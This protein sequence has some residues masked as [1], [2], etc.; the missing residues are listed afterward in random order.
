MPSHLSADRLSA[1]PPGGGPA[2]AVP[3]RARR[4]KADVGADRRGTRYD[5]SGPWGRR[6]RALYYLALR[7][8]VDLVDLDGLDGF[9]GFDDLDEHPARLGDGPRTAPPPAP[10]GPP[11]VGAPPS[12][13]GSAEWNLLTD[14]VEWSGEFYDILGRAPSTP[15]LTLDELPSLVLDAD[16]A[17]LTA[18]ITGCLVDGRPI[19]GEFRVVRPDGAV[20]TVHMMGEPVL[21]ADGGTASMWAVLRDV[22]ELRRSRRAVSETRDSLRHDRQRARTGHRAAVE[23]R[24]AAP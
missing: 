8:F 22:S 24:E 1:Q 20:R 6:Q 9:D 2:E 17:V 3:T 15:P 16:R 13:V 11:I 23:P 14:A 4:L 7:P 10:A 12:R 21:D 5:G 18:L 19:D